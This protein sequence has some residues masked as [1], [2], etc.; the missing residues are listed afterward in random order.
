MRGKKID[1]VAVLRDLQAIED[2]DYDGFV[3][4]CKQLATGM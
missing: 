3:L 4:S 2:D 1:R